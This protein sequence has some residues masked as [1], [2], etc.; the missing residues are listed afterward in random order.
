MT[1]NFKLNFVSSSLDVH[2]KDISEY[3]TK[4][5]NEVKL[6]TTFMRITLFKQE[7]QKENFKNMSYISN[8]R[9]SFISFK[10]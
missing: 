8:L 3:R 1:I 4:V 6:H 10:K 7:L 9:L 5:K 2:F